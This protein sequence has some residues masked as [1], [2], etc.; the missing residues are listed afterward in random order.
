[1]YWG[2]LTKPLPTDDTYE[3]R[4][5]LGWLAARLVECGAELQGREAVLK[6]G[7]RL[8]V[9]VVPP[10]PIEKEPGLA[11]LIKKGVVLPKGWFYVNAQISQISKVE[12]LAY[13]DCLNVS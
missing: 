7:Q 4:C 2:P 12:G 10:V 8:R 11:I 3:A 5:A 1:M 6:N 13:K 9:Y